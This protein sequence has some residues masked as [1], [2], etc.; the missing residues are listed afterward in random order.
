MREL[1]QSKLEALDLKQSGDPDKAVEVI[2]DVVRGE[3]TAKGR[4]WSLY[5]PLGREANGDL[6]AKCETM[7]N[8]VKEWRNVTDHLDI[9]SI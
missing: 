9:D 7:L 6:E 1:I 5:L 2:V 4:N 3:G 8:T